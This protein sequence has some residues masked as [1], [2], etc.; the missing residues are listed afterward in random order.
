MASCKSCSAPLESNTNRCRYCGVRNDV[1]LQS[2]HDYNIEN[3]HSE[4]MCPHCNIRLQTISLKGNDH[5]YIERCSECFGLF[6]DPGKI[7]VLLNNVVSG[8]ETINLEH[9]RNINNDRYQS[10]K[11]KYIKC[12]VCQV[13]MNRVSFGYR[14]GVIIDRC[15]KHGVWLDN[16]E[17]THLMEWKKA[18]GQLLAQQQEQQPVKAN[19]NHD[20]NRHQNHQTIENGEDPYL[21]EA[22]SSLVW[23]LFD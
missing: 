10:K 1:D 18:G 22:V 8:T 16:G 19:V 20:L 2:K 12:P 4:R 11:V 13:L 6:F 15:R 9:I 3:P 23:T 7:E 5:L 17:I 21:L 14:S